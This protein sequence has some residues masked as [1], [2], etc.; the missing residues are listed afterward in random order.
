MRWA[1]AETGDGGARL[2]PLDPAGRA[3]GPIVEVTAA[4]GGAV[5]AV[6]SRPDV[7]RWVWRST[8]E[9]YPRLLAAG[10]RVE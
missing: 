1:L 3:A 9:L 2:C 6:R 7:E 8:S 10:I 4:A 5:E